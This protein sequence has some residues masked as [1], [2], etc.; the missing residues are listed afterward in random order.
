MDELAHAAGQDPIEARLGLLQDARF[1]KVERF[2]FYNKAA[3][4][5]APWYASPLQWVAKQRL[6]HDFFRF[7]VEK[8]LAERIMP[9]RQLS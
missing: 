3:F 2:K 1:K 7:P 4:G 5:K 8:I 6:N 9:R